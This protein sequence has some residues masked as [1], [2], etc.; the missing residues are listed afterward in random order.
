MD[1]SQTF[2]ETKD[3]IKG[4]IQQPISIKH[5]EDLTS[6][7]IG[8]LWDTYMYYSMLTCVFKYFEKVARDNHDNDVVPLISDLLKSFD[9]RL[10]WITDTFKREN[11]R[12]PTGFSHN[13]VNLDAPQLYSNS[14]ILQYLRNVVRFS[15]TTHTLNINMAARP[16]VRDFYKEIINAILKFNERVT[17]IMLERGILQRHPSINTSDKVDYTETPGFLAGFI[18]KRQSLLA[19]EIANLYTIAITNH[20]GRV[21]LTGFSQVAASDQVRDYMNKGVRI[22][23][24][25]INTMTSILKEDD[26]PTPLP[27]DTITMDSNK[28]PFSDKLMMLH[29]LL[30]N[31]NG[32]GMYAAA[33]GVSMRHDLHQK[34]ALAIANTGRFAEEGIKIMIDNGWMEEPPQVV[35]HEASAKGIH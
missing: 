27:G 31:M 21:L 30:L 4:I 25:I 3:R 17:N 8:E 34:Y 28:A 35:E 6:A 16:D 10:K 32:I 33:M 9:T 11:L 22:A 7:E 12:V 14:Y 1:I 29:V 19:R 2:E 13:D 5:L 20:I 26:I 18:G 15:L 24:D 23:G